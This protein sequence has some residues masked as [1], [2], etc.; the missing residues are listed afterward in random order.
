MLLKAT[1]STNKILVYFHGNGE[2][3]YLAYDLLSHIRNNL[4]IHVLAVEYPGYGLYKGAPCDDQILSDSETVFDYLTSKLNIHPKDIII[5]GRSMGSG[6]ATYLASRKNLGA[7]VLMS[8]FTSIRAVV[9]DLAGKWATYLVKERFNNLEYMSRVTCPSFL[10]HGLRDSLIPYKQSQELHNACKGPC[11]L[12]LPKEMDHIEFDFYED[13]TAPLA[14]FLTRCNFQLR[15]RKGAKIDFPASL[16][17]T[18]NQK[19]V[20]IPVEKRHPLGPLNTIH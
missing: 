6:P 14:F 16:F 10:I 4:N 18:P 12:V 19:K 13:F 20:V 15:P 3:I 7:L 5:F 17:E 2:D 1:I 11:E 8:A 9:R